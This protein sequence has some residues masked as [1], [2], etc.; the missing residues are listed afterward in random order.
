MCVSYKAIKG[1]DVCVVFLAGS[2]GGTVN[3]GRRS[4]NGLKGCLRSLATSL[5]ASRV[6]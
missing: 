6:P 5:I 3:R 2:F 4:D 1:S